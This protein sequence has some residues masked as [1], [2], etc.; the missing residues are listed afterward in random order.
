MPYISAPSMPGFAS[1]HKSRDLVMLG[2]GPSRSGRLLARDLT[3]TSNSRRPSAFV[4]RQL[5]MSGH[6]YA[7][8]RVV[9]AFRL[10]KWR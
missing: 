7:A 1:S 2:C 10:L 3:R 5:D 4:P 9:I 8:S 6:S